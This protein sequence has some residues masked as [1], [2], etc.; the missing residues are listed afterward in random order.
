MFYYN[1]KIVFVYKYLIL[2]L[3]FSLNEQNF[4]NK[5]VLNLPL[6]K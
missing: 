1:Q 6:N 4:V 2:S 3:G 5:N